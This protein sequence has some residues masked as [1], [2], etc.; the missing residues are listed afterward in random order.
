MSLERVY[1]GMFN[2]NIQN[3]HLDDMSPSLFKLFIHNCDVVNDYWGCV[4]LVVY[5][6]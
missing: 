5:C 3:K 2:V 6:W 1:S 4:L